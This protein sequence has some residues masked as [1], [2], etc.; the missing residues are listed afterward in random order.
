MKINDFPYGKITKTLRK[1]TI[2]LNHN[3]KRLEKSTC[4]YSFDYPNYW[5]MPKIISSRLSGD[6]VDW[7]QEEVY[8]WNYLV[9]E[10]EYNDKLLEK[11]K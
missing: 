9:T 5:D 8:D 10:D 4:Q 11:S 3:R 2:W 6:E 1:A 7:L